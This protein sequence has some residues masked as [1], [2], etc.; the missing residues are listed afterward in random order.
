MC[1]GQAAIAEFLFAFIAVKGIESDRES[2][3][4]LILTNLTLEKLNQV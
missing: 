2:Y 4:R 3:V 1:R